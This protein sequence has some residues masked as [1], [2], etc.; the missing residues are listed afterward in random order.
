MKT[1][2]LKLDETGNSLEHSLEMASTSFT[3]QGGFKIIIAR[4]AKNYKLQTA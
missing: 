3:G 4:N 1:L 2:S